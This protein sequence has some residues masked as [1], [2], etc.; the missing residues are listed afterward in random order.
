V[1]ETLFIQIPGDTDPMDRYDLYEKPLNKALREGGRLGSV[2]GGG[3][4][5]SIGLRGA[6]V[7]TCHIDLDVANL[8]KAVPVILAVLTKAK[9]PAGTLVAHCESDSI[10]LHFTAGGHEVVTPVD[11]PL[12]APLARVP[13]TAGE[14]IGY[15]LTP[16]RWVLLHMIGVD[17]WAVTVRVPEW[18]GAELPPTDQIT[19]LLRRPP[20]K[21]RLKSTF[22][23]MTSRIGAFSVRLTRPRVLNVRR[24]ARTGVFAKSG[25]ARRRVMS[26]E[27]TRRTS[28]GLWRVCSDSSRWT[29]RRDCRTT[30]ASA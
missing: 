30:S 4:G 10:L 18:C 22:L 5:M 28:I 16:D 17:P 19:D 11:G 12:T 13:W 24:T 23:F 8:R 14:V 7:E 27:P 2:G 25:S 15:R 20:T 3:S 6:T 21:Y 29:G 1:P 9:V 26:T